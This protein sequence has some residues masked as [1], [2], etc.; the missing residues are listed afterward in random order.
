MKTTVVA[1]LAV[2]SV[3]FTIGAIAMIFASFWAGSWGTGGAL[4]ASGLFS[5]ILAV[6]SGL[7]AVFIDS[8]ME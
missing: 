8:E 5:A 3:M 6:G 2:F 1:T 4:F 7:L